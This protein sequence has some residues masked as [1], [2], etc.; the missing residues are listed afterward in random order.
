ADGFPD[1]VAEL[2]AY[3][4]ADPP[5]DASGVRAV[6]GAGVDVPIWILGSSLFGA[7]LAAALGLPFAFASHFAPALLLD[8]AELYRAEFRPSERLATSYLMVGVTVVA[9]DTDAEAR[10]LFTSLQQAFARLRRG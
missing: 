6:P 4:R 1:D 7:R 5:P 2:I 8:A 10:Y 3:F 9:A